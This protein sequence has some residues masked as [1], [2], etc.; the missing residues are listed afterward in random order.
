MLWYTQILA[1]DPRLP[2]SL[3]R[4]LN[5]CL[6]CYRSRSKGRL[7][8]SNARSSMQISL[9]QLILSMFQYWQERKLGM[10][11]TETLRDWVALSRV[12][13]VKTNKD[14]RVWPNIWKRYPIPNVSNQKGWSFQFLILPLIKKIN[15][16][17]FIPKCCSCQ[18]IWGIWHSLEIV[19][20]K[21]FQKNIPKEHSRWWWRLEQ[22]V[23]WD[24]RFPLLLV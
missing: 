14:L 22:Q 17:N 3:S 19:R 21:Y 20:I 11:A 1:K 23:R 13:R 5:C 18:F 16:K 9:S 12:A 2:V 8:S 6:W 10:R 4:F 7:T 15:I 24:E